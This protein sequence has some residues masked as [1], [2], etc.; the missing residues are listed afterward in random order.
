MK[1]VNIEKIITKRDK[2]FVIIN[3]FKYNFVNNLSNSKI[4]WRCRLPQYI[5]VIY[6]ISDDNVILCGNVCHTHTAFSV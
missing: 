1:N 2:V 4:K 6:T 5:A 3:N